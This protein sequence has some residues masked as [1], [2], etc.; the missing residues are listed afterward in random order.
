MRARC[1]SCRATVISLS[2]RWPAANRSCRS[3]PCRS[4]AEGTPL[5]APPTEGQ[6][7]AADYRTQG[8]TLGRHPLALLREQLD[9]RPHRH[10]SR[11]ARSAAWARGPCR[12]HRH[13]APA[14]AERR[15][16]HVH[17]ARGRNRL[18]EPHR[19]GTRV[20]EG[21]AHRQWLAAARSRT[22]CCRRRGW[23]RT[24][25]RRSSS[26]AR[27]MLGTHRH[28]VA[29]LP[30]SQR[31][32]GR[33]L[34]RVLPPPA[35]DLR[36]VLLERAR[37]IEIEHARA[38]LAAILEI[39]RDAAGDEHERPGAASVHSLPTSTLIVPAIT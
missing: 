21:A 31:V 28:A 17:H 20:V 6:N 29:R 27:G 16:R 23:S 4:A 32:S 36:H 8:L 7:I 22:A 24:W 37:R 38:H 1:A 30:L 35:R 14:P 34:R 9:G 3:R 39:V 26:T 12:G 5:L 2:G 13:G 18:R 25:W 19:L 15:W 11:S 33:V 10:L